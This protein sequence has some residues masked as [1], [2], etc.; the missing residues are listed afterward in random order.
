MWTQAIDKWGKSSEITDSL[1]EAHN[2]RSLVNLAIGRFSEGW[3]DYRLRQSVRGLNLPLE[4]NTLPDRLDGKRI[5]INFDQG[6]GDELFSLD[7]LTALEKETLKSRIS[8]RKKSLKS[9]DAICLV[10]KSSPTISK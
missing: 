6:L 3:Q 1:A 8:H 4:Q 5:F 2:N 9:S 10:N 7:F